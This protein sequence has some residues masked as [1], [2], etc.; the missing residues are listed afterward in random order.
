MQ[1]SSDLYIVNFLRKFGL[2]VT[3]TNVSDARSD[4]TFTNMRMSEQKKGKP[5]GLGKGTKK[6]YIKRGVYDAYKVRKGVVGGFKEEFTISDIDFVDTYINQHSQ[7]NNYRY[8]VVSSETSSI[9]PL[10]NS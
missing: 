6:K 8:F 4:C 3:R 7:I 9:L 1:V 5:Y 2:N 10:C